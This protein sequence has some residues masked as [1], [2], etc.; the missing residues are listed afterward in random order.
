MIDWNYPGSSYRSGNILGGGQ[1]ELL[2][3]SDSSIGWTAFFEVAS[4]K[5]GWQS[6]KGEGAS[7]KVQEWVEKA[8]E[9]MLNS[10]N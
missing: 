1:V 8:V 2:G 10:D 4:G 5:R 9:Y 7:E 3:Q 6:F